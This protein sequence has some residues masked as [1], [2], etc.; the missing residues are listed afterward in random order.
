LRRYVG[1][2]GEP[3]FSRRAY[4]PRAIAQYNLGYGRHKDAMAACERDHPGLL[5]GGSVRDGIALPD[6]IL[7]GISLANRVS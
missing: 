5:I 7:S 3:V 2:D 6:C 4:W 1:L